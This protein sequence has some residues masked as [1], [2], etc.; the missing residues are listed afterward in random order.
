MRSAAA[1]ATSPQSEGCGRTAMRSWSRSP[2]PTRRPACWA[3]WRP[4]ATRQTGGRWATSRRP[5]CL[6]ARRS[7]PRCAVVAAGLT[8]ERESALA[9]R[10]VAGDRRGR[11]ELV[12]A[13][14]P[15]IAAM[16]RRYRASAT[17]S[18]EELMQAGVLGLLRA[19]ERYQP[20]RGTPFWAYASWWV[21]QAMQHVVAE[22]AFPVV[23]SDRAL[24]AL[25][26]VHRA[27]SAR[28]GDCSPRELAHAAGLAHEHVLQLLA[29]ERVPDRL[30]LTALADDDALERVEERLASLQLRELPGGLEERER[31][32]V[33]AH[34]GLGEPSR[35]LEE[36]AGS[37]GVTA[38]RV[39][40]I[41]T[42][43]L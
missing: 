34:F 37:L 14:L 22:L 29:G 9:R 26:T 32:V 40:Q 41:E 27:Q 23:L 28:G 20:E 6:A 15:A 13:C 10:A 24:R 36:I 21:R 43:A 31:A 16:T 8:R 33:R 25:A 39:R 11:D 4:R 1:G 30:P 3:S 17:I 18:R 19:L 12:A 42:Q 5:R 7:D 2:W 35:T 38:E